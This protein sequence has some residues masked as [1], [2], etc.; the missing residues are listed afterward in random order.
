M[1][2]RRRYG[3]YAYGPWRGCWHHHC[4]PCGP[5]PPRRAE[6][7]GE[8]IVRGELREEIEALKAHLREAEERLA[9][10][11]ARKSEAQT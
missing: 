5:P 4:G 2:L 10:L 7:P 8:D 9:R 11:E 1:R 6:E 3:Q